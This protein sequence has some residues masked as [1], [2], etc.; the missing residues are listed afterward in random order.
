MYKVLKEIVEDNSEGK[1][2]QSSAP[3]W[4]FPRSMQFEVRLSGRVKD[5]ASRELL[6]KQLGDLGLDQTALV[7]LKT[8]Q[9]KAKKPKKVKTEEEAAEGE[10]KKAMKKPLALE[11]QVLPLLFSCFIRGGTPLRRTSARHLRAS[12]NIKFVTVL[13]CCLERIALQLLC[14]LCT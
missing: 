12:R 2:G 1:R 6:K 7:D 4:F 8:G 5:D 3:C 10:M 14:M 11:L 13:S 9:I